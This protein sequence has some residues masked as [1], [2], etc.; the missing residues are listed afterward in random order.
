MLRRFSDFR[1]LIP[2][3]LPPDGLRRLTEAFD[4]L[5]LWE[6]E[7]PASA[8]AQAAPMAR[9]LATDFGAKNRL[10]LSRT[11]SKAGDRRQFRSRL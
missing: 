7:D 1:L 8:L 10:R 9:G 11:L 3:P 6:A 4:A 5:K 2:L